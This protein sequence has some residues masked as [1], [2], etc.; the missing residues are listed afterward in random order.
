MFTFPHRRGQTRDAQSRP[1]LVLHYFEMKKLA[2][3]KSKTP[4]N[5]V[6]INT[7]NW[8]SSVFTQSETRDKTCTQNVTD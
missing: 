6:Q 7:D 5:S 3:Q 8:S 2:E 4:F 1:P